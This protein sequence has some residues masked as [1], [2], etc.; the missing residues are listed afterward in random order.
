MEIIQDITVKRTLDEELNMKVSKYHELFE[1]S[2]DAIVITSLEGVIL[3]VNKGFE[4][5]TGS[6]TR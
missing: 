5:I 6:T 2:L 3:S 1:N 4:S